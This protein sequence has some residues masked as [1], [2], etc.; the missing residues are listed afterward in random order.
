MFDLP[1]FARVSTGYRSKKRLGTTP[2]LPPGGSTWKQQTPGVPWLPLVSS[3]EIPGFNKLPGYPLLP[4][5][6]PPGAPPGGPL[7]GPLGDPS[8]GPIWLYAISWK[9]F[10]VSAI[11]FLFDL[12]L[13]RGALHNPTKKRS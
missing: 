8:E 3:R 12:V 10:L 1:R 4:P 2:R 11:L 5:R 9:P 7:G 13:F 6:G